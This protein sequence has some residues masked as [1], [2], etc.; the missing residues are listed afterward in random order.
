MDVGGVTSG[1]GSRAPTTETAAITTRGVASQPSAVPTRGR[2]AAS[3]KATSAA[4][5]HTPVAAS[6]PVMPARCT[7]GA[8][9]VRSTSGLS[10]SSARA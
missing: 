8:L 5:A 9:S 4:A 7:L 1:R 3:S 2:R 10:Q 6:A